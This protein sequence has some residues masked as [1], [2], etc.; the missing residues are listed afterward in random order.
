M[1]P[2]KVPQHLDLEDVLLW[3]LGATDLLFVAAAGVI[4]WW[5][6]IDLP[7]VPI[8]M[9]AVAPVVLIGTVLGPG[10]FQ[11]RAMRDWLLM[12]ARYRAR[13]RR[14]IFGVKP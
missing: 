1:K 14:R 4:A 11:E 2:V 10:T 7:L 3:G 6:W 8:R 9:A 5:L 13:P 12:I